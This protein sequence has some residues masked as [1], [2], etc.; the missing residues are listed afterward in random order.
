MI[1]LISILVPAFQAEKTII[2]CL[3]SLSE[4][5]C[6][7]YEV[8]I[9]NDGSMDNTLSLCQKFVD[10]GKF[11]LY[12]QDNMGIASTRQKLINYAKGEYLQFVDADDWVASN[13]VEMLNNILH[14]GNYDIIITD[15]IQ[16]N[17]KKVEYKCQ[18]PTS[19]NYTSF[20]RDLSSGKIMGVLW[21]K[22]IK[23]ELFG[24]IIFPNLR[25]CEDWCVCLQ[26][27]NK[28]SNIY[29]HNDA[30]YNYDNKIDGNSLTRNINKESFQSRIE[31]INYLKSI[32]FN[33]L[34]RKEYNS[35]V[36]NI[37]YTSIVNEVFSDIEYSQ[38][39]RGI[40]CWDNYMPI[41][42][43]IIVFLSNFL[44]LCYVKRCD[45]FVRKMLYK[46]N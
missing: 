11:R 39:F 13:M 8:I 27:F 28:T 7:N 46:L 10:G 5:T 36:V 26:L 17:K 18:K 2:R 29:Y 34:Y 20:I 40:S 12:S 25:Y 41:Y 45:L 19:L 3:K 30:Y 44:K 38:V 33:I 31:Y 6:D 1:P 43:K 4:Q 22:L 21:N 24:N 16:H 9:I 37:A 42:K 15:F 32:N 14:S 35:R 23:R